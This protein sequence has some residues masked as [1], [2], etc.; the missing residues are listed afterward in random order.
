MHLLSHFEAEVIVEYQ[1]P[2]LPTYCDV[3]DRES[4]MYCKIK[5]RLITGEL[6][7]PMPIFPKCKDD[8]YEHHCGF[9]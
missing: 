3:K 8:P 1:I 5:Q 2:A 9:T 6:C 7:C 4:L